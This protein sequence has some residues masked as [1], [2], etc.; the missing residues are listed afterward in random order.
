MYEFFFGHRVGD[1]DD[2]IQRDEGGV[3]L[4][5]ATQYR[6]VINYGILF[7]SIIKKTNHVPLPAVLPDVFQHAGNF[8]AQAAGTVDGEFFGSHS[9]IGCKLIDFNLIPRAGGLEQK[10]FTVTA[11][12]PQLK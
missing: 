12:D 5:Q 2:Q 11:H 7:F 4:F 6:Q 10:S 8:P 1:G 3:K 9:W